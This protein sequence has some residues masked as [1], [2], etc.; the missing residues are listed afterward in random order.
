[1][2]KRRRSFQ[3]P[4]KPGTIHDNPIPAFV[5]WGEEL[6]TSGVFGNDPQTGAIPNDPKE[7]CRWMFSH[8]RS[9]LEAAGGS[10]DDI[11][12]FGVWTADKRYKDLVNEFWLEM[13]PDEHSRPVRHTMQYQFLKSPAVVQCEFTAKHEGGWPIGL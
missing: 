1:M 3:I 6:F 5:T 4:G 11:V 13:F 9:I 8:V 12:K 2:A 7:Q 10:P